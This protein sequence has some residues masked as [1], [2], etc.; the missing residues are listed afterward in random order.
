[1]VVVFIYKITGDVQEN[2]FGLT[3]V[4]FSFLTTEVASNGNHQY[5]Q[6]LHLFYGFVD[7]YGLIYQQFQLSYCY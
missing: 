7:A 4:L 6:L 5:V 2:M 3:F 1:M